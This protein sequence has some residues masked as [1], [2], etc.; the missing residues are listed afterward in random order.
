LAA[1]RKGEWAIARLL[2]QHRLK[3]D[4]HVFQRVLANVVYFLE[5][6]DFENLHYS[7]APSDLSNS[8]SGR[9]EHMQ[10]QLT[11]QL[12]NEMLMV[13]HHLNG[14][15]A[16]QQRVDGFDLRLIVEQCIENVQKACITNKIAI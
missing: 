14:N 4:G 13:M 12:L 11:F 9:M 7:P 10:T 2:A 16:P 8:A 5:H 1:L 6:L 15:V 3:V